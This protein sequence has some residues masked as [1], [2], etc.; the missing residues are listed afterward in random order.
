MVSPP[1]GE[2][3]VRSHGIGGGTG[4]FIADIL[5]I[6]ETVKLHGYSP[7]AHLTDVVT[8]SRAINK[9]DMRN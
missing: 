6:I 2:R 5:T 7:G 4:Y 3:A 1:C 9:I 8:G